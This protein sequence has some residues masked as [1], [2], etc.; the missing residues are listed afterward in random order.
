MLLNINKKRA[1]LISSLNYSWIF[2]LHLGQF[3]IFFLSFTF[4]KKALQFGHLYFFAIKYI[5]RPLIIPKGNIKNGIFNIKDITI[6]EISTIAARS[7]DRV[8]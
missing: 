6:P 1:E 7:R 3:F 4:H 8:G 5:I 2:A